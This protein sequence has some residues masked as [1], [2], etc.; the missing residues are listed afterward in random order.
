MIR[1]DVTA[2]GVLSTLDDACANR[3]AC[4]S[5][6]LAMGVLALC[7][8]PTHAEMSRARRVEVFYQAQRAYEKGVELSRSDPNQ[9]EKHL[10]EAANGFQALIDD[11]V[12]NGRL[13]YNLGNT[14][15]RLKELGPAILNYRKA[16]RFMP[17]NPRL[18]EGLRV[19]RSLRRNDIPVTGGTALVRA[20]LFWHYGSSLRTRA[21]LGLVLYIAFWLGALAATFFRRVAWR[22]VLSVVFVLWVALGAS[23]AGTLYAET[24]H[25]E[26]VVVADDVTVAKDPGIGSSPAF[27][28]KLHQG[29]EFKLIDRQRDW[30]HIELPNGKAGW[31]ADDAVGLI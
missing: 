22:Y 18:T 30:L 3:A 20:L 24:Y 13:H 5:L 4:V 7:A 8:A 26:G 29:V 12:H 11:G 16:Q 2:S 25:P 1:R 15:L 27:Q 6:V 14:Y 10:R 21:W 31:V 17:D 28:E 9:A 19:A 23:V